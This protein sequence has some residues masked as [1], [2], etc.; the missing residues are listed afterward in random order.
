VKSIDQAGSLEQSKSETWGSSDV[1][2]L[3]SRICL[4]ENQNPASFLPRRQSSMDEII[5]RAGGRKDDYMVVVWNSGSKVRDDT[6]TLQSYPA[7]FSVLRT[8]AMTIDISST[9]TIA[10]DQDLAF[11]GELFVSFCSTTID[12]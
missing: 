8:G 5:K 1:S 6:R 12:G 3:L 4:H 10:L 9:V 2:S 7:T 11:S